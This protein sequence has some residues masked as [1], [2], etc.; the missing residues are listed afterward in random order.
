MRAEVAENESMGCS[1]EGSELHGQ[2][3]HGVADCRTARVR[4]RH[5]CLSSR[6][7]EEPER[8]MVR[9]NQISAAF[10]HD[11]LRARDVALRYSFTSHATEPRSA[12][13]ELGR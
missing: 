10:G 1:F 5:G 2:R 3:S 11:P 8:R 6:H 12:R 4:L 9:S 13:L 7:Q